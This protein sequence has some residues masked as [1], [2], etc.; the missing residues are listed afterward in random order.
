MSKCKCKCICYENQVEF[1]IVNKQ[2]YNE[3]DEQATYHFLMSQCTKYYI[4][5]LSP[6]EYQTILET[7]FEIRNIIGFGIKLNTC[8]QISTKLVNK[9]LYI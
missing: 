1:Q 7:Y 4:E 3:K 2:T 9:T 8:Y 6:L 5:I